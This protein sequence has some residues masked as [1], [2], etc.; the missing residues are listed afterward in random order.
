MD[1]ELLRLRGVAH[2]LGG[3]FSAAWSDYTAGHN[4]GA[5]SEAV[6][7]AAARCREVGA[8]Y[9]DALVVFLAYVEGLE[10]EDRAEEAERVRRLQAVL[11]KE[12]EIV[13]RA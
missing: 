2:G 3:E 7:A 4:S 1:D 5:P 9:G 13:G 6:V 12:L 11:A 10:G 8:R